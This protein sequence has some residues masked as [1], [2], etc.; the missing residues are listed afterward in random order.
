MALVPTDESKDTTKMYE[1]LW[2]KQIRDLII[3]I[4]NNLGNYD[5]KNVKIKFDLDD[6]LPWRLNL[7]NMVIVLDLLFLKAKNTYLIIMTKQIQ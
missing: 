4:T 7:Y 5:E 2:K 1:C 6:D 3:S